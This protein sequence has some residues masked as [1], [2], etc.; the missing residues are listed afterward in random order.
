MSATVAKPPPLTEYLCPECLRHGKRNVII[1]A[2]KGS[3]VE[4]FCWKCK[5]RQIVV[6]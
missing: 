6:V 1:R 5:F 2:A 3:L 4:A